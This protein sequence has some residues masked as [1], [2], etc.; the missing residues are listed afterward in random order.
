MRT[1][2][3]IPAAWLQAVCKILREGDPQ[4]IAW[5]KRAL[6]DWMAATLSTFTYEAQDAMLRTLSA[7]GITGAAVPLDE[8]GETYEFF[9]DA[10]TMGSQPIKL[11]GKICL[12]PNHLTIKIISAH[13]P[14]K[15]SK[16]T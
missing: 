7:S 10:E 4:K 6:Q 1:E 14:L 9:F 15:G 16:L 12:R 5:T 11:Y 2:G 13:T 8:P 3:P